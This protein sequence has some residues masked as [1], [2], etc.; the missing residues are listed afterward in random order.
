MTFTA[1]QK[2]SA[3]Q[4][5]AINTDNATIIDTLLG[6][7]TTQYANL[8]TTV[9]SQTSTSYTAL[10]DT[11]SNSCGTSFIAPPSGAVE[12]TWGGN[13]RNQTSGQ[14]VYVGT[15]V[16]TG[17]TVGA[18]TLVSDVSD[19]E[20]CRVTFSGSADGTMR[21]RVVTGL[22]AG[23]TYNVRQSWKVQSGTGDCTIPFV[24]VKPLLA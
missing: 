9:A 19:N 13:Y 10:L 4:L 24:I 20:T 6:N 15:A 21:S 16:K 5:N 23:D 2:V 11:S 14:L 18:G 1:G 7:A 12:I 8:T 17:G 3:S 22:T